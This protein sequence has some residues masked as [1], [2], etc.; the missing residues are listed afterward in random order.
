LKTSVQSWAEF[1]TA[2]AKFGA[3]ILAKACAGSSRPFPGDAYG[4]N[5]LATA[6]NAF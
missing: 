4:V 1:G 3:T 2:V 6:G 5:N